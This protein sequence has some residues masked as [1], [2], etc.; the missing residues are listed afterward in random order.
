MDE[1]TERLEADEKFE[2]EK[3]ERERLDRERTAKNRKMREQKRN[4]GKKTGR[5]DT[6]EG[7]DVR[8]EDGRIRASD[9]A[10]NSEAGKK[11][12]KTDVVNSITKV[13]DEVKNGQNAETA[14]MTSQ[15]EVGIIIHDDAGDYD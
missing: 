8:H 11:D 14:N 5:K 15:G 9:A 3:E 13:D 2:K 7:K 12:V 10:L 1:E 6:V 4:K